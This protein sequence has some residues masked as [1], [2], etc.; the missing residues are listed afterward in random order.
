MDPSIAALIGAGITA[1]VTV[2][3]PRLVK[4]TETKVDDKI[5]EYVKANLPE[6][7]EKVT[8]AVAKR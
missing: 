1:L 2:V 5:L 4:R 7:V 6:I 8:R 3:L